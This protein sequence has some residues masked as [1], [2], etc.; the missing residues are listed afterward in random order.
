MNQFWNPNPAKS[1]RPALQ[2]EQNCVY[3]AQSAMQA[4][5]FTLRPAATAVNQTRWESE[6]IDCCLYWEAGKIMSAV[7]E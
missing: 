4:V 6:F 1:R 5:P 2:T 3:G 7:P